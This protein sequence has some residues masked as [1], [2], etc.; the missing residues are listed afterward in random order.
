MSFYPGGFG[1]TKLFGSRPVF[2][3]KTEIKKVMFEG[4]KM[5]PVSSDAGLFTVIMSNF[6][7]YEK[8]VHV[9]VFVA[10]TYRLIST[11]ECYY[12]LTSFSK[13]YL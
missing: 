12:S 3:L 5:V 6:T 11:L 10:I 4:D 2:D 1:L 8:V 13:F 7:Q 9:S